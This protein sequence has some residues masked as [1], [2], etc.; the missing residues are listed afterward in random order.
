[1][2]KL[3]NLYQP[4]GQAE[5]TPSTAILEPELIAVGDRIFRAID[6][7]NYIEVIV[8]PVK[9]ESSAGFDLKATLVTKGLEFVDRLYLSPRTDRNNSVI[10]WGFRYF[11]Y[12]SE[13]QAW[14]ECLCGGTVRTHEKAI[15]QPSDR[16]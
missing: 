6:S 13:V 3:V 10:S 5:L 11:L 16:S 15:A 9:S 1:M 7:S 14:V 8:A 4:S 2:N 12:S